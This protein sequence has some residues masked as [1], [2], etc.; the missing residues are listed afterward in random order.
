MNAV[1]VMQTNDPARRR[2]AWA[3]DVEGRNQVDPY[4]ECSKI[5]ETSMRMAFREVAIP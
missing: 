3:K 4:F 2:I 5:A 1:R